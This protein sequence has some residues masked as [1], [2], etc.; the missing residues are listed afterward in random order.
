MIPPK[1]MS[2]IHFCTPSDKK[3]PMTVTFEVPMGSA[4]AAKQIT[5]HWRNHHF[6]LARAHQ[7]AIRATR[8][9]YES[10]EPLVVDVR[11]VC[12]KC[13]EVAKTLQAVANAERTRG[14][15]PVNQ[16][17]NK[18]Y[19]EMLEHQRLA[20][21]HFERLSAELEENASPGRNN[22]VRLAAD[23]E[24]HIRLAELANQEILSN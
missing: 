2:Y 23:I 14:L 16:S 12:G 24:H 4:P 5:G 18:L 3:F 7:E 8:E 17:L 20:Y 10:L 6:W 1:I 13:I 15:A 11:A 21:I 9:L 22:I 19:Q